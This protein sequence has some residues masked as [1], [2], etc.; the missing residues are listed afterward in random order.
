MRINKYIF[1]SVSLFSTFFSC[2]FFKEIYIN[3]FI[4]SYP[5]LGQDSSLS[6]VGLSPLLIVLFLI[7]FHFSLHIAI[8]KKIIPLKYFQVAFSPHAPLNK[9]FKHY[10]LDSILLLFLIIFIIGIILESLISNILGILFLSFSI[11]CLYLYWVWIRNLVYIK[12]L[13][14]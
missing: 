1:F 3:R 8:F 7:V 5:P 13:K 2:I 4:A 14:E 6:T 9:T 11:F 10:M 12:H